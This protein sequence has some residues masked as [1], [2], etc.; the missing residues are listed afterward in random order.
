[1]RTAYLGLVQYDPDNWFVRFNTFRNGHTVW[2]GKRFIELIGPDTIRNVVEDIVAIDTGAQ[3]VF[4]ADFGASWNHFNR[5][6]VL[7]IS[8]NGAR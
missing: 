6:Q 4:E 2:G 8:L 7:G 1:M 3:D 5:C